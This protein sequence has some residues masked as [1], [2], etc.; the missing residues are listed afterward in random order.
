MA[1]NSLRSHKAV[2]WFAWLLVFTMVPAGTIPAMATEC[3]NL[4]EIPL[5]VS[6]AL[7]APPLFLISIDNSDSM[8]FEVIAR[9]GLENSQFADPIT[10]LAYPYVFYTSDHNVNAAVVELA[11]PGAWKSQWHEHNKLYYNPG[12]IYSPWPYKPDVATVAPITDPLGTTY[13]LT[14][15][16]MAGIKVPKIVTVIKNQEN[17]GVNN[18]VHSNILTTVTVQSS[19]ASV[20]IA[21]DVTCA[22][23]K[24]ADGNYCLNS[25]EISAG[26]V[27]FANTANSADVVTVLPEKALRTGPEGGWIPYTDGYLTDVPGFFTVTWHVSGLTPGQTYNVRA[28]WNAFSERSDQVAYNISYGSNDTIAIKR[29]HFYL[30]SDPAKGGDG[31]PYLVNLIDGTTAHFYKVNEAVGLTPGVVENFEL[32]KTDWAKLPADLKLLIPEAS[33]AYQLQNFANWFNYYRKRTF[34][35]KNAVASVV[36]EMANVMV[37]FLTNPPTSKFPVRWINSLFAGASIDNTTEF[38]NELYGI[39][40]PASSSTFTSTLEDI[41][42]YFEDTGGNITNTA[43]MTLL[44]GNPTPMPEQGYFATSATYPY[45][46]KNWGGECQQTIALIFQ[47]AVMLRIPLSR[48]T[49]AGVPTIK[50]I[51]RIMTAGFLPMR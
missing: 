11:R 6:S 47:T 49:T 8:N 4:T 9:D 30:K 35:L 3:M 15:D 31:Y 26:S 32:I 48:I 17:N 24:D 7:V 50:R 42:K 25:D 39:A 1:I 41:G 33:Y 36:V 13:D 43:D 10:G 38:L 21:Q 20:S 27:I 45:M 40:K 34:A 46:T 5:M 14:A 37:G 18:G 16:F 28:S 12:I 19:T 44:T 23:G 29:R 22:N 2:R 51:T